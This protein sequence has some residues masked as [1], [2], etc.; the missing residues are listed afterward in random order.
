MPTGPFP[1]SIFWTTVLVPGSI[2]ETVP[3]RASVTQTAP[4]PVVIPLGL[5][6]TSIVSSV[7]LVAGSILETLCP[8]VFVTQI[9]PS[10]TAT[11]VGVAPTPC[12]RPG[13]P[14]PDR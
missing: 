7:D 14:C 2:R 3:S 11:C 10:P 4:F 8:S 9:A 12:P 1:T 5:L 6:P 13:D